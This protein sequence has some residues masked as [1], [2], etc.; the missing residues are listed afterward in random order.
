MNNTSFYT[1]LHAEGEHAGHDGIS[2]FLSEHLG[3]LGAFIDEV[4]RHGFL[5]TL[6]LVLFLFLVL[7]GNEPNEHRCQ[8][9]NRKNTRYDRAFHHAY[10]A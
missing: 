4:L 10:P 9:Q 2:G 1:L 5:D 3:A 8:Q 7:A 6:Q